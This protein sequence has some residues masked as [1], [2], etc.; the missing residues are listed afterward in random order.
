MVWCPRLEPSALVPLFGAAK[1][2]VDR[3]PTVVLHDEALP[4]APRLS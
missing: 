2:F 4:P 1:G 3:I